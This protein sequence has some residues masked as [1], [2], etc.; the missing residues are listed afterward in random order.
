MD[1]T[2]NMKDSVLCRQR[3]HNV[4]SVTI[5]DKFISFV[6]DFGNYLDSYSFDI[7]DIKNFH[8]NMDTFIPNE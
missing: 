7:D 5:N 4:L 8:Y 3:L 1:I 2:I 6:C